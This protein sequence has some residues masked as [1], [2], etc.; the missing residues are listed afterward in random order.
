MLRSDEFFRKL[1][2]L[3]KQQGFTAMHDHAI[4]TREGRDDDAKDDEADDAE[5]RASS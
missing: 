5:N 2:R 1:I 3:Y 4:L